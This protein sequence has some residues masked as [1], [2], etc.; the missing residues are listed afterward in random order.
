M[1]SDRKYSVAAL[2]ARKGVVRRDF[3][4]LRP[5][6]VGV[7][8][9]AAGLGVVRAGCVASFAVVDTRNQDVGGLLAGRGC[10]VAAGAGEAAMGVMIEA[11]VEQ[12]AL[13][14]VGG[15]HLR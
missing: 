5:I 13:R 8:G 1:K 12:P 9:K 6:V 15:R 2:E 14:D 7:A 4:A 3:L 11:R 10:G